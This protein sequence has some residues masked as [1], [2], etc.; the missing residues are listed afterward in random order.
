MFKKKSKHI[1]FYLKKNVSHNNKNDL[2]HILFLCL[3][4]ILFY[5]LYIYNTS[6]YA[7]FIFYDV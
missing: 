1:I 2:S 3:I 7:N 6:P 4:E 5:I